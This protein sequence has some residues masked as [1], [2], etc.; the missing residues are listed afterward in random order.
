MQVVFSVGSASPV[1]RWVMY[2]LSIGNNALQS[3]DASAVDRNP[4]MPLRHHAMPPRNLNPP[5]RIFLLHIEPKAL[6]ATPVLLDHALALGLRIIAVGK[7]HALISGGLF[8]LAHTAGL[9]DI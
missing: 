8:V 3:G 2:S 6:H 9:F 7:Q 4:S 1:Y 5:R